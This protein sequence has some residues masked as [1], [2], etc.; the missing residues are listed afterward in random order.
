[1]TAK[2]SEIVSKSLLGDDIITGRDEKGLYVKW[3]EIVL[4]CI[5]HVTRFKC[6]GNEVATLPMNIDTLC[7]A[8]VTVQ[9]MEGRLRIEMNA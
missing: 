1:M 6:R 2:L 8:T 5:N 4:D 9:G 3:D 7:D